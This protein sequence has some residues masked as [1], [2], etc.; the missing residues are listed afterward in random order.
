MVWLQEELDWRCM[1]LYGITKEDLSFTPDHAF[2]LDK[3]QR[4][5]EFAIARQMARGKVETSWFERHG[6][7]P[8]TKLPTSWLESYRRRVERRLE[9]IESD[10]FVGLLEGP[11]YKRRWAWEPWDK[12]AEAAL[13]SWLLN[14]LESPRYWPRTEPR[15]VA[16]LADAVRVDD[17]FASVARLYSDT[18]EVDLVA[19]VE[20]LTGSDAVPY[21]AALRHN[22][23]GMCKRDTWEHTWELQRRE[24]AGEEVGR[25]PVPPKYTSADFRSP[26]YWRLRGKLDVA[27]ER[28]I[29]YPGLERSTDPTPVVGWTG[30][31]HLERA[32]ALTALKHQREQTEGWD[33][34]KLRPLLAGLDELVPWL[35]QWH[36]DYDSAVGHRLG[37]Y[38]A[39]Y[40]AIECNR[41]GLSIE[42][43]RGWRPPERRRGRRKKAGA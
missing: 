1:F 13:R 5:F 35:R 2:E 19:L 22:E 25:I 18:P 14:R 4:A 29:S 3:G 41:L 26:V 20:G 39:D 17:D 40:L 9:L 34:D 8:I 7:V 15:S 11:E 16:Q 38:F 37:D 28:F 21:L 12:L 33:A 27:K 43:L 6:S 42:D 36:N 23:P 31:D 30:W 10:R 24:D 32:K